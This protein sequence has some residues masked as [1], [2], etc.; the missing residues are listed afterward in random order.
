MTPLIDP[1]TFV[2]PGTTGARAPVVVEKFG[3][4]L[5]PNFTTA[6]N[7]LASELRNSNLN[8][9]NSFFLPN[10]N[11]NSKTKISDLELELDFEKVD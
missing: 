5:R 8:S 4:E 9:L 7:V 2:V 1:V 11:L 3:A 6:F 10:S